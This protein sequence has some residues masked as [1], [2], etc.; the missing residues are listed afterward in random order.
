MVDTLAFRG[1]GSSL[2]RACTFSS[3]GP[4]QVCRPF[5]SYTCSEHHS[6]IAYEALPWWWHSPTRH[7][8][9]TRAGSPCDTHLLPG[10]CSRPGVAAASDWPTGSRSS[11][12]VRG[13][14]PTCRLLRLI[15]EPTPLSAA[16]S[17]D[18]KGRLQQDLSTGELPEDVPH[19]A[20]RDSIR[21]VPRMMR[22][23]SAGAMSM[24]APARRRRHWLPAPRYGGRRREALRRAVSRRAL[25]QQHAM[26]SSTAALIGALRECVLAPLAR[27]N[28][29]LEHQHCLCIDAH[30]FIFW[31]LPGDV[32]AAPE[33]ALGLDRCTTSL[34]A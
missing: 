4:V 5:C 33:S 7:T 28:Y 29:H 13:A 8:Q 10:R 24:P 30:C 15:W 31:D 12:P 21:P 6:M 16:F 32:L 34:S 27:K 25:M 17:T 20:R 3:A 19:A 22:S 18:T 2:C 14:G 11:R 26:V 9:S 1:A 23:T